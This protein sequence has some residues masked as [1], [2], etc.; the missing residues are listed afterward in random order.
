MCSISTDWTIYFCRAL[1][2]L[3]WT[4]SS[5]RSARLKIIHHLNRG[6]ENIFLKGWAWKRGESSIWMFIDVLRYGA[7]RI[8]QYYDA[9]LFYNLTTIK[10]FAHIL[11][12][13][14]LD[15]S[16]S[17]LRNIQNRQLR[18]RLV[19]LCVDISNKTCCLAFTVNISMACISRWEKTRCMSPLLWGWNPYTIPTLTRKSEKDG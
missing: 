15:I 19:N 9:L 3:K 18:S 10:I 16:T 8:E 5:S 7:P 12:V 17:S 2:F 4:G 14:Q 11:F 6:P 1:K 13:L